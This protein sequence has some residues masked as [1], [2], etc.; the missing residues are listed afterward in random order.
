M[1][2]RNKPYLFIIAALTGSC[3]FTPAARRPADV[4]PCDRR[5]G[6]VR[7]LSLP[8]AVRAR[9]RA[10]R[11]R[12]RPGGRRDL[13][14]AHGPRVPCRR[15]APA[16]DAGTCAGSSCC[17]ARS[18]GLSS[19]RSSSARS[20]RSCSCCSRSA[21]AGST[22]P[23]ASGG[24]RSRDA[25]QGP[26][27]APAG[28]GGADGRWRAVGI[29]AAVI[30][31]AALLVAVIAGTQPWFDYPAL[32]GRVSSPRSPRPTTSRR[33]R[34]PSRPA[35]RST[36]PVRSSGFRSA[37]RSPPSSWPPASVSP[38]PPISSR[39]SRASSCRRCSGITTRCCCSCPSPGS[40]SDASG[41]RS[42]SPSRR[43][44]R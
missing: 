39:S 11:D 30:A 15:R 14:R 7:D 2:L 34:S 9:D 33:A 17:S 22:G 18:T 42:R 35:C 29:A 19:T 21:G 20:V 28:L 6:R 8:A 26:A 23:G 25:R 32:L 27:R 24:D 44:S 31:G 40:S 3:F 5:R 37:W 36:S 13:D 38:R 43:R 1:F 41:G 16:G 12:R 10:A 4:R